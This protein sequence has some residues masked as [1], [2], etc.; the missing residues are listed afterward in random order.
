MLASSNRE[1]SF[2]LLV[3]LRRSALL[4][5]ALL[6]LAHD[7]QVGAH[8]LGHSHAVYRSTQ[9]LM[10]RYGGIAYL[11]EVVADLAERLVERGNAAAREHGQEHLMELVFVAAM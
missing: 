1:L 3:A 4:A 2:V 6:L 11:L 7:V 8:A 5:V 10:G 9:D